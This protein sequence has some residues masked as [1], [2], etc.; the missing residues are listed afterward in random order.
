MKKTD[1]LKRLFLEYTKK[2][3]RKISL[4]LFFALLVAAST[5]SIA[6][7]LDPVIKK[8]F[9]EKDQTL[10]LLIPFFIIVAFAIKGLSLYFAKIFIT[11]E[12]FFSFK[13]FQIKN[14][15]FKKTEF[16]INSNNFDFFRKILNFNKSRLVLRKRQWFEVCNAL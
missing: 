16:N 3:I 6:Y 13:N 9:V 5:S 1:I 8:I 2:H 14:L 4:S 7:L 12:N 10:I 11:I 15:N